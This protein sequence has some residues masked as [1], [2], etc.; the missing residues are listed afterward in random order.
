MAKEKKGKLIT[1]TSMKG[2]VGKTTTILLLASIYRKLEKKVLL[3]D[4]DLYT[5]SIAFSL[6]AEVKSS[7]FNVCDDMA[8]N[9][10]KGINGGEYICHYDEFI[11]VLS[12]PKDPRQANKVD[13]KCLEILMNSLTNYYDVIL[14]DTNHIL[15]VYKM[16]AFEYS[17]SIV[18]IFTN[19]A[20]DLKG[21]KNFVSIC[22]NVGVDNFLLV[23]NNAQDDRKRYFSDYDI[24]GV[25]KHPIDYILPTSLRVRNFD[26]YVTEGKLLE[27]FLGLKT[28]N[29]EIEKLALRLLEGS[30]KGASK[31]EEK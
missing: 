6:N 4:L 28:T 15:D 8:N 10:Y 31:D 25:I 19:D 21:T 5:G 17:D 24:K 11:D 29:K 1:V 14:V 22:K 9:R 16:I 27:Y 7:I 30:K 23:L 13:T 20:F 12:S 18:N 26:M 2:G 3:L